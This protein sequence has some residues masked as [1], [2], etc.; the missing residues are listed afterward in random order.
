MINDINPDKYST[1]EFEKTAK[2]F[3]KKFF[4]LEVDNKDIGI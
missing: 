2:D 1:E 4:N 3:Y